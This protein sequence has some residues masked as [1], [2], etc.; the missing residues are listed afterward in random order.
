MFYTS[1]RLTVSVTSSV[2]FYCL[3]FLN[4]KRAIP[5]TADQLN[6]REAE[7][8]LCVGTDRSLF[9]SDVYSLKEL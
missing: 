1:R 3:H 5:A 8:K 7:L 6:I 4:L 9:K 2:S